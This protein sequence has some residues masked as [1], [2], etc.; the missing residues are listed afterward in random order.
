MPNGPSAVAPDMVG[1]LD[2]AR[3]HCTTARACDAALRTSDLLRV[4]QAAP[5][6]EASSLLGDHQSEDAG[7]RPASRAASHTAGA[8][9]PTDVMH[10]L[11]PAACCMYGFAFHLL[12]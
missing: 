1:F 6:D 9:K 11:T 7:E 10:L 2:P 8:L 3:P 5:V 4:E 12:L